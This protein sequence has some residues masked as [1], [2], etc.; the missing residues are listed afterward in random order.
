MKKIERP[1]ATVYFH[2]NN[3]VK[4]RV[5]AH[6]RLIRYGHRIGAKI[7]GIDWETITTKVCLD[8]PG[9][10]ELLTACLDDHDALNHLED[11]ANDVAIALGSASYAETIKNAIFQARG[12]VLSLNLNA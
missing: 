8:I 12:K 3:G 11:K 1:E 4:L 7:I 5:D 2:L 6:A 10:T 9:Y